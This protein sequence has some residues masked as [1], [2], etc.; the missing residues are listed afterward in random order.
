MNNRIMNNRII[1][2]IGTI[3]LGLLTALIYDIFNEFGFRSLIFDNIWALPIIGFIILMALIL[4]WI[5]GRIFE[6]ET[7]DTRKID[8][9]FFVWGFILLVGL[10]SIIAIFPPNPPKTLVPDLVGMDAVKASY[11]LFY[12]GLVADPIRVNGS[13]V[14]FQD[15]Q[16]GCLVAKN[17]SVK[18]VIGEPTVK[19]TSPQDKSIINSYCYVDGNSSGIASNYPDLKIY[20]LIYTFSTSKYQVQEL[21]PP[22]SD[23]EWQAKCTFENIPGERFSIYAV[24]TTQEIKEEQLETFPYCT[25]MHDSICVTCS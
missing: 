8:T 16:G 1:I 17:S 20:I 24:I 7:E 12:E 5:S 11:N 21:S 2:I 6:M 18:I 23:G 13:E 3:G 9:I 25:R 4:R 22:Q 14:T 19:I 10:I 15:P